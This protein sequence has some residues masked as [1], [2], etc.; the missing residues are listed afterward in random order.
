MR[1]SGERGTTLIE[2]MLAG[3]ILLV[4]MLGFAG[5][6]ATAARSTAV[7][8]RR[9][10]AAYFR[11]SLLDRYVVMA[12][13]TYASI[14][15]GTWIVDNC[16][17]VASRLV[18][19]NATFSTAFTCPEDSSVYRSWLRVTGGASGPWALA[20]YAE[21]IDPGCAPGDRYSSV[22]CVAADLFVSD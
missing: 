17:D 10:A 15:A 5:T 14:P 8:H 2:V 9:S 20:A 12:R 13:S 16:Y 21:R 7:A 1:R 6:A 4:A 18:A 3:A 11:S 19:T 22:A